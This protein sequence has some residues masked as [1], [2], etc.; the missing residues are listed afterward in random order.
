MPF[1]IRCLLRKMWSI[2]KSCSMWCSNSTFCYTRRLPWIKPRLLVRSI[3]PYM[4]KRTLQKWNSRYSWNM[5]W[6]NL[7]W[8]L[9]LPS[10]SRFRS[11]SLIVWSWKV[12]HY[13][14]QRYQTRFCWWYQSPKSPSYPEQWWYSNCKSCLWRWKSLRGWIMWYQKRFRVYIM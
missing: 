11:L 9:Y 3:N 4:P 2:C 12:L 8:K 13:L 10:R 7:F 1:V 6:N 5:H 14:M